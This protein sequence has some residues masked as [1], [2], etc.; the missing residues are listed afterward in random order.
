[1]LNLLSK[2]EISHHGQGLQ[3]TFDPEVRIWVVGLAHVGLFLI[4]STSSACN[5]P[6]SRMHLSNPRNSSYTLTR[7]L[8]LFWIFLALTSITIFA[9]GL[10]R[11]L[12]TIGE[13]G[14]TTDW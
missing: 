11:K 2:L 7:I 12:D 5:D 9:A 13:D 8:P 4:F 3:P 6:V 14:H 1:M 10:K